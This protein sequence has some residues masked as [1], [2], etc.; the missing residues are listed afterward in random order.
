MK[1]KNTQVKILAKDMRRDF[2]PPP[3][4]MSPLKRNLTIFE[5][6]RLQPIR[7]NSSVRNE[8]WYSSAKKDTGSFQGTLAFRILNLVFGSLTPY[9]AHNFIP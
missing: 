3:I 6:S 8:R 1:S 9:F 5:N 4:D 2:S 7:S